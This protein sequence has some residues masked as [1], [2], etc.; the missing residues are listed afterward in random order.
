MTERMKQLA[1][2]IAKHQAP[3]IRQPDFRLQNEGSIILLCPLSPRA[4]DWVKKYIGEGNGYQPLW[5]SVLI[6]P[7]YVEP[8]IGGIHAEG[9]LVT[10]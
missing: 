9:M 4:V 5:P 10:A 6:E 1:R 2:R 3:I 7:R 8:I